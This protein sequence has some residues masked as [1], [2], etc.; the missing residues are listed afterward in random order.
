ML[1]AMPCHIYDTVV[2]WTVLSGKKPHRQ[3]GVGTVVTSLSS[4][5]I[6]VRALARN[7]RDVGSIPILDKIFPISF[8]PTTILNFSCDVLLC[9]LIGG[10]LVV[11]D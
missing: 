11:V 6:M 2:S 10:C 3:V 7:T 4:R 1:S 9:S 8:T 5:G